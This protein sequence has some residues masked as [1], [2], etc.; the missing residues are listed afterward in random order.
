[1]RE[2]DQVVLPVDEVDIEI[3]VVTPSA[4]PSF[5]IRKPITAIVE[6]P[7]IDVA[8]VKMVLSPERRAETIVWNSPVAV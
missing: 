6:S 1:M 5:V 3:V 4:R 2:I 8:N 7:V